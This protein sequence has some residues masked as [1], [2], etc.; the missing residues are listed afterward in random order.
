MPRLPR[1]GQLRPSGTH[2]V[3]VRTYQTSSQAGQPDQMLHISHS[4]MSAITFRISSQRTRCMRWRTCRT[5]TLAA[6]AHPA[7][8][9]QEDLDSKHGRGCNTAAAAA[10]ALRPTRSGPAS[11]HLMTMPPTGHGLPQPGMAGRAGQSWGARQAPA[12]QPQEHHHPSS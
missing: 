3:M 4:N 5:G 9:F 10:P 2:E 1:N 7:P 8:G 11:A 6:A 12:R